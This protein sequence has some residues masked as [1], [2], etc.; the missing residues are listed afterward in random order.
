MHLYISIHI[1]I[2]LYSS[3]NP[4]Y[5][6]TYQSISISSYLSSTM[7]IKSI[8]QLT[9]SPTPPSFYSILLYST[10]RHQPHHLSTL[11]Y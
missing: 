1:S 2:I 4:I 8:A 3:I 6:Q 11:F 10:D 5:T 9:P 7:Y